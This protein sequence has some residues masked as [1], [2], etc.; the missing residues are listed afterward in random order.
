M[1]VSEPDLPGGRSETSPRSL[2]RLSMT[3]P[4]FSSY[5]SLP[6]F[7]GDATT[8]TSCTKPCDSFVALIFMRPAFTLSGVAVI[9]IPLRLPPELASCSTMFTAVSARAI[10]ATQLMSTK[11]PALITVPEFRRKAASLLSS[12]HTSLAA[13]TCKGPIE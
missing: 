11:I 7:G 1:S 9:F 5:G 8:I 10:D 3:R 6:P 13:R 2:M 4:A 12:F